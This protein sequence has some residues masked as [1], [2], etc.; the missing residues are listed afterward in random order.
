VARDEHL[1]VLDITVFHP[2]FSWIPDDASAQLAFLMLDWTLGEDSVERWVRGIQHTSGVI[3]NSIT[4]LELRDLVTRL[5]AVRER[6]RWLMLSYEQRG[7]QHTRQVLMERWIDH[8]TLDEHVRVW[9]R[10]SR[11]GLPSSQQL[12]NLHAFGEEWVD[13][14]ERAQLVTTDFGGGVR[15]WHFYVDG[16]DQNAKDAV[17]TWARSRPG[18][19][20]EVSR[21]PGWR[22]VDLRS[23]AG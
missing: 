2:A 18:V 10:Y 19:K 13:L 6:D 16:E 12:E 20:V 14:P 9:T 21:D 23:F 7:E 3:D 17:H 11:S 22:D 1:D 4:P 8:P 5:E 15:E